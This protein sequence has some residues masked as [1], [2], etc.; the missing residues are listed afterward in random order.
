MSDKT[1]LDI[2]WVLLA[3]V[4]VLLM[5]GGFLC[6]ESGITRTKNSINVALKNAVDL[7][8][9]W[10]VFWLFSFGLMF[11]FSET[12][13]IGTNLFAPDLGQGDTW[14]STFFLFQVMFC[15]TAAT[16][17]SGAVAERM[18]FRAYILIA[19]LVAGLIYPV[20][21]HWAWG[22][23]FSTGAGWL[24]E[25]GFVDFAG[26]TV[27]HSVGGWVALAGIICI[28][29]RIG[30]FA[31]GPVS[32]PAS[33]LPIA[34]LG[35]ILFFVGWVGFNGGSTL[36]FN[37]DV[38]GIVANTLLSGVVG[39]LVGYLLRRLSPNTE[40]VEASLNGALAGLVAITA[41]CHAVSSG[42]AVLTG[43]GGAVAMLLTD[44][45]MMQYR[46]DDA[47]GAVPVHLGAGIWGSLAVALFGDLDAI[48][49]GLTRS[50]QVLVQFEGIVVCALWSFCIGYLALRLLSHL[51]QLRVSAEDEEQGL[52]VSEH[53]AHTYLSDLLGCIEEQQRSADLS[54]RAPEEPF[55][56]IGQIAAS[57]NRLMGALQSATNKT[58]EIVRQVRDG[59]FTFDE[60]GVLTSLNPGAE[61][62]LSVEAGA[63]VGRRA[64][65]VF[66]LARFEIQLEGARRPAPSA[67]L[68]AIEHCEFVREEV[69]GKRT[70]LEFQ[71]NHGGVAGGGDYTATLRDVSEQRRAE[72]RLFEE[73][74]Q[75]QVTLA[76]LGEAVITANAQDEILYINPVA[77]DLV[78]LSENQAVGRKL[79]EAFSLYEEKEDKPVLLGLSALGQEGTRIH[80]HDSLELQ[81]KDGRKISIK[82]TAAPIRDRQSRMIGTVLV[83][84][85]IST[86]RALERTLSYQASHDAITGL[87]NRREFENRLL[88]L[89][90][91]TVE[92]GQHHVICYADL[93]QFKIVNDTC[94]HHAGDE[95]LRQLGVLLGDSVRG[96]DT[97][98]R[99]GGDEFGILL[100]DC[101]IDRGRQ[102]ADEI[103]RR[104]EE[105][106]FSW[107]GRTFA[108]GV[109]IGIAGFTRENR[110]AAELMSMAD[111]ACYTA[112]DG[113]R[114]R[115]QLHQEGDEQVA[116][117]RGQMA[118]ASRIREAID[119]DRFRLFCQPIVATCDAEQVDHYE[120]FV[121]MLG[122]AGEQVMPGA[123]IPAAE[124]Y[125]H[126]SSI[127]QWV[128]RNMLAW[129][130]DA[131]A[132][133]SAFSI[134]LSGASLDN[135]ELLGDIKR[136]FRDFRVNPEQICFEITETAAIADF[137]RALQFIEELKA[138]G[139]RFSL[140]DFGSGLSS[141][142]YL[143][144][145]PVDF[146]KIDGM[147]VRDILT[148]PFDDAM[149][150]SINRIGQLMGL[151][152]VAE[153]VESEA[154]FARLREIGVDLCQGYYIGAPR[155][156]E[157]HADARLWPR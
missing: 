31:P 72:E 113:G 121:R 137:S 71:A 16:I 133:D 66:E 157:D 33:N 36:A 82:L 27:V 122:D 86:A 92:A 151:K 12:G 81:R 21:G 95:L 58:A 39:M 73:K 43:A 63:V 19:I 124:R 68:Q 147:F 51:I 135:R 42:G 34:M 88:T 132:Q 57:Y 112:K 103:R 48:G 26:S 141:F 148:D 65:D 59:I 25:R 83:F 70:V 101:S 41:G 134:N 77:V 96:S 116:E 2:L 46:L 38:P 80:R 54:L 74:E 8:V 106:R 127:D 52:N 22:G 89:I 67:P 30:R 140:D 28:G 109:S 45:V 20:F 9:V 47:V 150:Q 4:L 131:K 107:Q 118:W 29:P 79:A 114:N 78:G 146:I 61:K 110:N 128:V 156:L 24:Q 136:G 126:M 142:G 138:L 97:L 11:G 15:A 154:I 18:R 87:F 6:L 84:Q 5:Q 13:L 35:V 143:K 64:M 98:A 1:T 75:A 117:R 119:G 139:C 40:A 50:Q 37:G 111:A 56:E 49:T 129:M 130:G 120:V 99:L 3:S 44:R 91:N 105:F 62:L 102:I 104:I 85:D 17:V 152:T 76:S 69:G 125:G 60:H 53:G 93:D 90:N 23:A 14:L 153:F 94:G 115:V 55:T 145:L 123:F 155:P 144:S 108:V 149:V 7:A 32:I 10:V 100:H